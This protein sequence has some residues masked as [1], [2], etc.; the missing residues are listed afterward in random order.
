MKATN[1]NNYDYIIIVG[2]TGSGKSSLVQKMVS[3]YGM[4]IKKKYTTRPIRHNEDK[5]K[6]ETEYFKVTEKEMF[7][8]DKQG[9]LLSH[10]QP[11]TAHGVWHYGIP[12]YEKVIRDNSYK[13]QIQ[14]LG[15]ND[16]QNIINI[17]GDS[18]FPENSLMITMYVD[19]SSIR[20]KLQSRLD[21]EESDRRLLS[22]IQ[23]FGNYPGTGPV[24]QQI[25]NMRNSL[26]FP[27]IDI[28]NYDYELS[29]DQ[30][31]S[32]LSEFEPINKNCQ[33]ILNYRDFHGLFYMW[34]HEYGWD[35]NPNDTKY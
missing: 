8:L 2:L 17:H 20:K 9:K 21:T 5:K 15:I 11:E 25:F 30:I 22:D 1:L 6:Y 12:V 24:Y 18:W 31:L 14:V 16:I 35:L 26:K 28:V 13:P 33:A 29:I 27:L 23:L 34:Q 3:D 19:T 10:I 7:E 4:T 32:Y